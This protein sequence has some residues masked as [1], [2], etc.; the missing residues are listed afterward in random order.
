MATSRDLIHWTEHGPAFREAAPEKVLGSRS[1]MVVSRRE[2][3]RL[4]ATKIDG[5]YWMYYVHPCTLAW[6]ENLI[7][8]TPLGKAVW[9]GH[10]L[11]RPGALQGQVDAL[12]RRRRPGGRP[13]ELRRM[14]AG[15]KR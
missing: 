12:L 3:D 9:P 6:S 11:Q 13:G 15:E 8:W 5:R 2:G 4:I 1:G 7:D 10:G 14:E